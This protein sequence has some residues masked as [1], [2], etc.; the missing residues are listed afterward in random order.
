MFSSAQN[1]RNFDSTSDN[2]HSAMTKR[3]AAAASEAVKEFTTRTFDELDMS[4]F[5]VKQRGKPDETSEFSTSYDHQKLVVNL[6]PGKS[7]LKLPWAMQAQMYFEPDESEKDKPSRAKASKKEPDECLKAQVEIGED[8]S[9][10]LKALEAAVHEKVKVAVPNVSWISSVKTLEGGDNLFTA[11]LVLKCDDQ[12]RLTTCIVRPFKQEAVKVAGKD[13]LKPLLDAH[14]SFARSKVKL[15][16]TPHYVYVMKDKPK[17]GEGSESS[18]K[19][20]IAGISWRITNL[21][22]DLPEQQEYVFQDVFKDV[23]FDDEEE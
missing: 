16:V 5:E 13:L 21:V 17:F 18:S 12:K 23:V 15:V 8:V 2:S 1:F 3:S 6:T 11:K 22:A 7:W 10:V 19:K 14:K 9:Q 20:W 4:K